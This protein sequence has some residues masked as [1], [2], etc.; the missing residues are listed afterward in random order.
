MRQKQITFASNGT[1][2]E[3]QP[4]FGNFSSHS[5]YQGIKTVVVVE[6]SV[7]SEGT[8]KIFP[9]DDFSRLSQQS[10][11]E[12]TFFNCQPNA[13][14]GG[15]I[16]RPGVIGKM[17]GRTLGICRRLTTLG[18]Q[19][20]QQALDND[21]HLPNTNEGIN[22]GITPPFKHADFLVMPV[23]FCHCDDANGWFH[24]MEDTDSG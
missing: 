16:Q 11:H 22:A 23:G 15:A 6:V 4:L 3:C 5:T 8:N 19:P 20:A 18:A 21:G 12:K 9:G 17:P 1:Q 2:G 14:P 13:F 7:F 10:L 24:L